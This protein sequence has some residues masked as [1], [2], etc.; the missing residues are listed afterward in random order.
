[1]AGY[2]P[3]KNAAF[4]FYVTLRSQSDTKLDQVNPTLAAGD[5]KVSTDGGAFA[6][7]TTIPD[8]NPVGSTAVRVRLSAAEMNGDNVMVKFSDVAGAEWCD[9]PISIQTST[10]QISELPTAAE[11]WANA[12]RTLT[13]TAAEVAAV[14]DGSDITIQRGDS[15]SVSL[16]GLGNI[17]TRTKLWFTVK[18][19]DGPDSDSVIQIEETG[20]L[21]YLNASAG[22]A[23][24]GDITVDNATT[25]AIT[26]TLDEAAT[27]QL[28]LTSG[29]DYD[30]QMLTATGVTTLTSGYLTV[31]KDITRATS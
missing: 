5:V 29:L 18:A 19:G 27:A 9:L 2:P 1:M 10:R 20:G 21:L 26:I 30:V 16:T 23:I 17:S 22:T 6:N 25:G 3:L 11:N 24:Q 31:S 13:Q 28:P 8:V 14:L 7:L 15:L 4:T 12:T